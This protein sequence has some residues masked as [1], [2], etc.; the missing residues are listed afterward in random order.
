MHFVA[1]ICALCG[2]NLCTLFYRLQYGN[3][4]ERIVKNPIKQVKRQV[5]ILAKFLE[6]YGIRVWVEGYAYFVQGNSPVDSKYVL[7][8]L[9]EI[10]SAIH[11]FGRKRLD[12]KTIE[13][14]K[15]L[16]GCNQRQHRVI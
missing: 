4:F 2:E 11:T 14:I 9:S 10:D 7:S 3:T 1:K 15:E 13:S 16:L 5:Y 8:D 12:E 6:Y